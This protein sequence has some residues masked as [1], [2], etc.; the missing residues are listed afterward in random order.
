MKTVNYW[1]F[2][3]ARS[4]F[5]FDSEFV[6]IEFEGAEKVRMRLIL[7]WNHLVEGRSVYTLEILSAPGG[8]WILSDSFC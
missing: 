3:K 8:T 1:L 4:C 6:F 7:A 2:F 5:K